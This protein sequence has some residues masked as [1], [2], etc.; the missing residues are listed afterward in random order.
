M[1]RYEEVDAGSIGAHFSW[2]IGEGGGYVGFWDGRRSFNE[3][4]K[5]DF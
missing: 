4:K 3:A 2:Q 1:S 5:Y